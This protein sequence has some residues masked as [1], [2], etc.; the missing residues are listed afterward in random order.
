MTRLF[1]EY[2]LLQS[3]GHPLCLQVDND[4]YNLLCTE[5]F[6]HLFLSSILNIQSEENQFYVGNIKFH[7]CF[8]MN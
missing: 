7:L 3:Y 5:Q 1:T 8:A 4:F 6:R 2:R